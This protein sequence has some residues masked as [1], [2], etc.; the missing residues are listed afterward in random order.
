MTSPQKRIERAGAGGHAADTD[1][2]LPEPGRYGAFVT[3]SG[4]M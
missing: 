1:P 4:L 2:S 3:G